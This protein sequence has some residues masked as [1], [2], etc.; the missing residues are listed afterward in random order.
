MW[1]K[2]MIEKAK[3]QLNE[4]GKGP[5]QAKRKQKKKKNFK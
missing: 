2:Y 1:I 5:L 4:K 3:F